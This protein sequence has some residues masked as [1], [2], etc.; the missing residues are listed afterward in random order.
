MFL[1]I[2]LVVS[3][4]EM[5]KNDLFCFFSF[6]MVRKIGRQNQSR[7]DTMVQMDPEEEK[8][9]GKKGFFFL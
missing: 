2:F 5:K 4:G 8:K 7:L 3:C 1:S 6:L 9:R